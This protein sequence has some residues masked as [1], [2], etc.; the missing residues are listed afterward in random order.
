[1]ADGRWVMTEEELNNTVCGFGSNRQIN[2]RELPNYGRHLAADNRDGKAPQVCAFCRS[3]ELI[4]GLGGYGE[5]YGYK[6]ARCKVCGGTTDFVY[7]DDI[8]KFF[9]K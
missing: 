3:A 7:K 1:M 5:G 8:G 9:E 4:T 2:M 6:S